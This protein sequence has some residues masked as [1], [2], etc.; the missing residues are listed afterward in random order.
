M[1]VNW[2][3][4][5]ASIENEYEMSKNEKNQTKKKNTLEN[6]AKR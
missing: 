5:L 4:K 1:K 6:Y 3:E 2:E